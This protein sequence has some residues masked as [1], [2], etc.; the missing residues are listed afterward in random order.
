LIP[1]RDR[2]LS[3]IRFHLQTVDGIKAI[4]R[5][6]EDLFDTM[7]AKS[8][9]EVGVSGADEGRGGA[10]LFFSMPKAVHYQQEGR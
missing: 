1:L 7:C 10:L 2:Y 5:A 4:C 6:L 8:A 3:D 9:F